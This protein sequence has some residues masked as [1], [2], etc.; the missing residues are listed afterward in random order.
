MTQ[1]KKLKLRK[2]K[3]I[4]VFFTLYLRSTYRIF[5]NRKIDLPFPLFSCKRILILKKFNTIFLSCFQFTVITG[6]RAKQECQMLRNISEF[7][8]TVKWYYNEW[9]L[10]WIR[11]GKG[12]SVANEEKFIT[13]LKVELWLKYRHTSG[14]RKKLWLHLVSRQ[15]GD[16]RSSRLIFN[17]SY[18]F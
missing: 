1:R 9:D 6:L 15:H 10:L 7:K 4:I 5:S 11:H 16:I 18:D 13:Q 8:I 2:E 17:F 3:Q 14:N 12:F